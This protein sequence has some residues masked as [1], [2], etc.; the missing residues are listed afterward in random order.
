MSSMI[1][2][3][4]GSGLT[5]PDDKRLVPTRR[6]LPTRPRDL[7][8]ILVA[9]GD[10]ATL[11][12]LYQATDLRAAEPRALTFITLNRWP[13]AAELESLPIPYKAQPHLQALLTGAES[14]ASLLRR[15]CD[16]YPERQRLC[17]VRIP[18]CAGAHFLAMASAMHP[19][20][21]DHLTAWIPRDHNRF[22]P[23]LGS[24]LGRFTLTKTIMMV[25]PSLA[26]FV[27]AA[28][29]DAPPGGAAPT[30]PFA[31][32]G[33]QCTPNPPARRAGDRL[34]TIL[35]EP[36]S[37]VLSSVNATLDALMQPASQDSPAIAAWRARLPAPAGADQ[38]GR[39]RIALE[40]LRA[41]PLRNPICHALADGTARGAIQAARLQDI[42]LADL[43]RYPNW[44]KYTWD[45]EAEPPANVSVPHLKLETLPAADRA[46][47]DSMIA[48][49]V[50]FYTPVRAALDS[51]PEL[52]PSVRGRDL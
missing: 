51:L 7:F 35:R 38:A 43:S 23:A 5:R 49:D 6:P 24:L 34:F 16:A 26:P 29:P 21:P 42:E 40:I 12:S 13:T 47:F 32:S 48:E 33:L 11:T 22:I 15:I 10:Q 18:N 41:S 14:R 17:F 19:V 36:A 45:V 2:S 27:Q 46:H 9:L 44:T 3:L 20:V 25:Q 8:E 1:E 52:K 28:A 30:G 37:L 39:Q 50:A 4:I 31:A